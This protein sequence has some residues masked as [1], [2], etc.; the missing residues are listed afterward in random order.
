MQLG[1][2]KGWIQVG[3]APWSV[4]LSLLL[5][6]AVFLLGLFGKRFWCRYVCP[7]GAVFSVFS[8]L[9]IGERKVEATCIGCGKCLESCP[10][11]A[12]RQD[13]HDTHPG[14]CLLPDLWRRVSDSRHQFR[15]AM[16]S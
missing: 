3:P 4:Y 1:L 10:F 11:D 5:F 6:A 2:T 12:I 15:H 9:R 14:L 13:Y 7:S 8:L 16:E